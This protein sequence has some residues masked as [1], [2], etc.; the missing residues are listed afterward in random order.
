MRIG[1][2]ALSLGILGRPL[3]RTGR[4]LCQLVV[5]LVQ[6]VEESVVPLR[7]LVGPRALEPAG[8]RVG[9]LAA[10][11]GVPPA[12][13]L[14]VERGTLGLRTDVL[15][16]DGTVSLADRVAADD[17]RHRLLV[18]HRHA[19]EGLSNVVGGSQ[20]IWFAPRPLGV[21]VDQAHLHGAERV[22]E[23]P[24][25]AVSLISEPR[26]LRAPEDLGGLR[27]V[28]S[29]EAEP[30]RLEPHRFVGAIAGEDDEIGPG[31]LAAVLLLD[32][33]EQPARLVEVRVVG[34]AVEG[35]KALRALAAT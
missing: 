18:V 28:L 11:E 29:P 5:V 31:D 6:V 4:A 14:R 35:G 12:E 1:H 17:E 13:A 10:A 2:G 7:R 33:P 20:R 22:G 25:T 26:V 8:D 21:H 27:D 24:G 19:T 3:L 32:R 16:T 30:E 15:L 23:L 34:P 9:A